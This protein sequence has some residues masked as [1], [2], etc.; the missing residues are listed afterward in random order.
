[1]NK[2]EIK[3]TIVLILIFI[4]IGI[5]LFKLNDNENYIKEKNVKIEND[6]ILSL[7]N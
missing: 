1:M 3:A 5:I 4:I 6:S 7:S 2:K